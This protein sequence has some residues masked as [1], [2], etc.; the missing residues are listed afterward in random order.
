[1]VL[2]HGFPLSGREW[3][4][5]VPPLLETGH[6]VVIYDRRGFGRS[7]QTIRGYPEVKSSFFRNTIQLLKIVSRWHIRNPRP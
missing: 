4:K 1:M 6:R 5:Q 7:T 3:E 2:I